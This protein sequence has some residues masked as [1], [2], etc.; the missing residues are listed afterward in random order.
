MYRCRNKDEIRGYQLAETILSQDPC[1]ARS[2]A[3][4]VLPLQV[5]ECILDFVGPPP[6]CESSSGG[7]F[8]THEEESSSAE[9][10]PSD[11]VPSTIRDMMLNFVMPLRRNRH[12]R[13]FD[14]D[15]AD[16]CEYH[17]CDVGFE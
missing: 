2:T 8:I 10:S 16:E 9:D 12:E 4:D 6:M 7:E 1:L 13:S 17:S 15:F 14:T 11:N 3:L 5:K